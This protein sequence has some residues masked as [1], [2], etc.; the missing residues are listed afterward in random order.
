MKRLLL[1]LVSP[2][3]YLSVLSGNAQQCAAP[4]D[5]G[6]TVQQQGSVALL[7]WLSMGSTD[8]ILILPAG[9]PEPTFA[10]V[11]I[12]AESP[13]LAT[14]L[15]CG[16]SY[17][18][19]VRANCDITGLTEWSGPISFIS[20]ENTTLSPMVQGDTN[21][22]GIVIFNLTTVEA[23]LNTTNSLAYFASFA[24]AFNN[25]NPISNTTAYSVSTSTINN[26][27][28]I[29]ESMQSG[30]DRFYTFS[31]VGLSSLNIASSCMYANSLCSTIGMPYLNTVNG[32]VAE[33]GNY[34]CLGSQ[35][36]PTWFYIP[37]S[38]PGSLSLQI[39]QVS[40]SGL[41]LDVD[42]IAYGPFSTPTCG[43]GNL[44]AS[45]EIACSYSTAPVENFTITNA[46]V[47]QYY[48][49]LV[50]NFSNQLGTITISEIG[51]STAGIDCTGIRMTAFLDSNS[52][53]IK[54]GA[55]QNF[56]LGQFHYEKNNDG[57]E[58]NVTALSGTHS[59]YEINPLN[60]YEISYSIDG[61]YGANYTINP[62]SFSNVSVVAGAGL[63]NYYFPIT[64]IQDYTDLSV[65][66][67]PVNAPQPGFDY[68]N[69]V[70]FSNFGS[71]P[72]AAGTL[73]F[74]H[75]PVTAIT[76]ITPAGTVPTSTGFT[77]NFTNLLPFEVREFLVTMHV[78]LIPIVALGDLLTNSASIVPLAGDIY[79]EN[80]S[81]Q[82]TQEIIGSYDPNDKIESRGNQ[83][84]ITD[85]TSDDY[86]YY[87]IRFENTGTANAMN[88]RVL[89]VLDESLN[90]SSARM[91]ASSH[92]CTLDRVGNNLTWNFANVQLPPT[93]QN[94]TQSHGYITFKVQ[95]NPG[96]A[97][98]DIVPNAA[99]IFFDFNP[100]IVTNTFHSEFV[101][102]LEIAENISQEFIVYPNPASNELTISMN[103]SSFISDI[104]I[105]D[106][107][108]KKVF[109]NI[110]P[111]QTDS[112]TVDISSVSSGIY[113]LEITS[114][115]NQKTVKNLV[116]Q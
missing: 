18:F 62:S 57:V 49:L 74:D 25:V 100:A 64:A 102:A 105:Y 116:I 15:S 73:T 97:V 101:A 107:L 2:I 69:K 4:I 76:V 59:I 45:N 12:P 63:Q 110:P 108:G 95:P 33:P 93:S 10:T 50:T 11:G 54:D 88:I 17:D 114:S 6:V 86:L 44:T 84:L 67:V 106:M 53:G 94:P 46:Q 70:I 43:I 72:I 14:G 7:Q 21:N 36:N 41:G 113:F 37:I 65:L 98:G 16:E 39:S 96:Y 109:T 79:P 30:C 8:E 75:D 89:D 5:L 20:V 112:Q 90:A 31:V 91:V 29:R 77:H 52:N 83:I 1:A 115:I 35:P 85:F 104:A 34:G 87:T 60:T 48:M 66:I 24:D 92:E 32:P 23:Q 27:V 19:Y 26:V 82:V 9:S 13:F 71:Q 99:S 58:H 80:N 47:G 38:E 81:S 78:P 56:P 103:G 68:T 3:L 51:G 111:A 61:V 22:D 40:M 28:V 55:E 42:F